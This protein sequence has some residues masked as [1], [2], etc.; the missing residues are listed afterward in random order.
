VSFPWLTVLF[1]VPI[2]GAVVVAALPARASALAPKQISLGVSLVAL[3]IA[4]LVAIGYHP[5]A[6]MQYAEDHAWI[7]SF[8][9]HYALGVD[10]I[11]LALVLMPRRASS[12][13]S[14]RSRGSPSASSRRPTSSCSTSSSR[15][16]W[17]RS[18]SWS[19]AGAGRTGRGQA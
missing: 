15:P 12:P 3:A 14:W 13:G 5:G 11:G 18:G 1:L 8:G 16:P 9:A 7:P 10:G 2:V 19:A 6:G 4:V 17:S